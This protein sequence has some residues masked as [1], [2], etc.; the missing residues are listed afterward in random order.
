L[1]KTYDI[2]KNKKISI[3]DNKEKDKI[4]IFLCGPTSYQ[5]TH[6]GHAR[7]FFIF[8]LI[9]RLLNFHNIQTTVIINITDLDPK[10]FSKARDNKIEPN[11]YVEEKIHEF[12]ELSKQLNFTEGMIFAKVS[13]FI[14]QMIKIIQKLIYEKDAYQGFGNIY[15]DKEKKRRNLSKKLQNDIADKRFDISAGKK[16]SDDILLWNGADTLDYFYP[17]CEFGKGIPWWHI[18][19]VSVITSLFGGKYDIHGGGSDLIIPHHE[20]INSIL[21]K[22]NKNSKYPR[23]WI[24]VGLVYNKNKKMSQTF[25]NGIKIK[26]LLTKYNA[27]TLKLYSYSKHYSSQISFN[28]R[29]LRQ[30]QELDYKIHEYIFNFGKSAFISEDE[31]SFFKKF[32]NYLDDDLNT[33]EAIKLLK[34]SLNE[35]SLQAEI[36]KMVNILGLKY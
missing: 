16:D 35:K 34:N 12:L 18:Q 15:L 22:F 33:L 23:F 25:N 29:D 30:Y 32:V 9:S 31:N 21:S 14:P 26:E 28:E 2:L 8:D 17:D 7:F 19:D 20:N 11:L 5:D 6:F 27:N 24:H 1:L 4:R 36:G 10:I 13:E 3:L